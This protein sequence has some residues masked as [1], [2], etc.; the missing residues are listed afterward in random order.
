MSAI[1]EIDRL[2]RKIAQLERGLTAAAL[3]AAEFQ[4]KLKQTEQAID[5]INVGLKDGE[6]VI[7]ITSVPGFY[8]SAREAINKAIFS[9]SSADSSPQ[10]PP[11]PSED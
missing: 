1:E 6:P 9:A 8:L 2:E 3:K 11:K 4:R 5:S 10:I 7:W